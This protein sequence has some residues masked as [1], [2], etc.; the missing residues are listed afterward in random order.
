MLNIF[1]LL[2]YKQIYARSTKIKQAVGMG[3]LPFLFIIAKVGEDIGSYLEEGA[4][5]A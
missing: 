3:L 4:G 1:V 5:T 2:L